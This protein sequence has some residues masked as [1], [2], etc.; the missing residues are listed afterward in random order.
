M[1]MQNFGGTSEEYD[2]IF[3]VRMDT[4]E[5]WQYF[6][7]LK[8]LTGRSSFRH[9]NQIN[10]HLSYLSLQWKKASNRRDKS[11]E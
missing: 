4:F 6:R 9:F 5:T 2:G 11:G 7:D 3:Y 1:L 10:R 8:T